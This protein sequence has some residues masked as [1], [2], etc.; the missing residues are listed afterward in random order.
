MA[1]LS[2]L[3]TAYEDWRAQPFTD[4]ELKGFDLS[5]LL[6]LSCMLVIEPNGNGNPKIGSIVKAQKKFEKRTKQI[7]L[8]ENCFNW[9]K[10]KKF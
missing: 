5:K 10:T 1:V 3:L 2:I 8:K 7:L 6:G 4:D 9:C